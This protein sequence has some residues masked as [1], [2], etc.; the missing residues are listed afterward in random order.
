MA[1]YTGIMRTNYFKVFDLDAF[2]E[3]LP[4][5]A[6]E[7]THGAGDNADKI[8]LLGAD[9]DGY[10]LLS[11]IAYGSD[12]EEEEFDITEIVARHLAP[13]EVAVFQ[14][15]GNEK[16]RYLNGYSVAVDST[17]KSV[18]VDLDDIY[19]LAAKEFEADK[20]SITVA[21]Y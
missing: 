16:L 13:G 6:F 19:V 20:G 7:I 11:G 4:N 21:E 5:D 10:N 3:D 15:I 17:G 9:D 8:A 1:N 14:H 12:G 18:R 2:S